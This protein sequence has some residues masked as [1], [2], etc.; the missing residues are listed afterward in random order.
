MKHKKVIGML[1][2]ILIISVGVNIVTAR[3]LAKQSKI[4]ECVSKKMYYEMDYYIEESLICLETILI[5]DSEKFTES[6][7]E[8][9]IN[10]EKLYR[11]VEM[12]NDTVEKE[13]DISVMKS[14]IWGIN[15]GL[16]VGTRIVPIGASGSISSQERRFLNMLYEDLRSIDKEVHNLQNEYDDERVA[17]V[18]KMYLDRDKYENVMDPSVYN[19]SCD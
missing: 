6:L 10:L 2:A 4:I 18:F 13:I 19:A 17:E 5:N 15:E 16:G 1:S 7:K 11:S 14:I 3:Q 8:L 9:G 12:F